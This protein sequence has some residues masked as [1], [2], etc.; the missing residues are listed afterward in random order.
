MWDQ[1]NRQGQPL[2]DLWLSPLRTTVTRSSPATIGRGTA[3]IETLV[4]Q[5]KQTPVTSRLLYRS[6]DDCIR[7]IHSMTRFRHWRL[8]T[9]TG[10]QLREMRN[11]TGLPSSAV[12]SV[13]D[14][15][16]QQ[17]RWLDG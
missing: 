5:S 6:V 15:T 7:S 11:C 13:L 10:P 3:N 9:P 12:M 8:S 1:G 4:A 2:G 17:I 14:A 16:V